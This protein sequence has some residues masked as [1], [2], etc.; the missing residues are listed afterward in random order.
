MSFQQF[1]S[2]LVEKKNLSPKVLFLRLKLLAPPTIDFHAGQFVSLVMS[3]TLRRS[4]SIFSPPSQKDAIDLMVDISVGGPGSEFLQNVALGQKLEFIGPLGNFT[5]SAAEDAKTIYF[6]ATGTGIAPM[7]SMIAEAFGAA[8][9]YP[10]KEVKLLWGVSAKEDASIWSE[11]AKIGERYPNFKFTPCISREEV[12][13][14]FFGRVTKYIAEKLESVKNCQFY[15]CG[16]RDMVNE[17]TALLK[18]KGV[19]TERISTEQ[20]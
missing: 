11:F 1:T 14:A 18:E 17:V 2:E 12:E 10:Q 20:Y 6:I 13:G 15:I 8:D 3:P 7:H 5:F 4:Y 9:T 19:S 16:S